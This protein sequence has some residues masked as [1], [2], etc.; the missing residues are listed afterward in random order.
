MGRSSICQSRVRGSSTSKDAPSPRSDRTSTVPPCNSTIPFGIARPSPT[1]SDAGPP[2]R[3]TFPR[4]R[5]RSRR[6]SKS[7]SAIPSPVSQTSTTAFPQAGVH[8]DAHLT[9]FRRVLDRIPQEVGS[10]D[11]A[12]VSHT[13]A[14]LTSG[15]VSNWLATADQPNISCGGSEPTLI[16]KWRRRWESNPHELCGPTVLS[17]RAFVPTGQAQSSSV[18]LRG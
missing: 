8:R 12:G 15:R 16:Q 14:S 11:S 9:T 7:S 6:G 2:E 13:H 3:G 4:G 17:V 18:T 10:V 5:S 1:L